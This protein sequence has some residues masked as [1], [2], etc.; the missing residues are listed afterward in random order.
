MTSQFSYIT[1]SSYCFLSLVKFSNWSEFHVNII[2][3]S[4]VMT[5]SFYKGLTRNPEIGNTPVWV[6]PN[7]WRLGRVRDTKFGMNVSNKKLLNAA[8]CH[9]YSFYRSWVTKG[10]Q[11][12]LKL[13]PHRLGLRGYVSQVIQRHLYLFMTLRQDAYK[14]KMSIFHNKLTLSDNIYTIYMVVL[15][16]NNI[17]LVI[18]KW[19]IM[20]LSDNLSYC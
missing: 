7:I 5:I 1:S 2:T 14:S 17:K 15:N 18:W 19:H 6:L 10:K 9:G 8:K 4:G 12:G 13:L 11:Q 3:G 16:E 20:L